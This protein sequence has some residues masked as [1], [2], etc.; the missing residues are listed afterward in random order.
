MMCLNASHLQDEPI[1]QAALHMLHCRINAATITPSVHAV[2]SCRSRK[3][4]FVPAL[5]WL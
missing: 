3:F 1:N 5:E 4:A 2:E